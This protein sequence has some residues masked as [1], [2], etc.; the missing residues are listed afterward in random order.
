VSDS[1]VTVPVYEQL[2][3]LEH[4]CAGDWLRSALFSIL[5]DKDIPGNGKINTES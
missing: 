2:S 3:S 1:L 4:K 5:M